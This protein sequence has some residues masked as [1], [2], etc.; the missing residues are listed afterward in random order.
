M[1]GGGISADFLEPGGLDTWTPRP[2]AQALDADLGGTQSRA[3][4]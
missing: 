2:L 3:M 1:G 4:P